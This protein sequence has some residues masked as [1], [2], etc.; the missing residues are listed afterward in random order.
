MADI[1]FITPNKT[2]SIMD[3]SIGTLLLTTILRSEGLD[4]QLLPLQRFGDESDFAAFLDRAVEGI[5][6]LSPRIVSFYTRCDCFHIMLTLAQRLKERA[7]LYIVFGG[8]HAD[9]CAEDTLR[10]IPWVDFV[11]RGEGEHTVYPLFSSLLRR[12]PDLSV[13]GLVYRRN[14]E[15]LSNPRP[16]LIADLD[17]LPLVDYSTVPMETVKDTAK[18]F[19]IDVGRGCPFGCTFCST[20]SFWGRKYRLKSPQR[21]LLEVEKLHREYGITYFGF[22]H[23][24]FTMNRAKVLETCKLLQTLD[25]PIT[26]RCSARIDCIDKEMI[27]AMVLSGMREIFIGIETGSARMQKL[28]NKNLK[29]DRVT[30][31]LQYLHEK[32]VSII[33]S[34]IYGFPEETEA[35]VTDTLALIAQ[36]AKIGNVR[37]DTHMCTFLPGTELSVR[38]QEEL[39]AA[40]FFSDITGEDGVAE[41]WEL[42]MAHPTLFRHFREYKTPLRTKLQYLQVFVRVWTAIQPVYQ[43][44]S[45]SYPREKL[46]DMY[47]DFVR[48]NEA[49]L[50]QTAHR[51]L[52]ERVRRIL[53]N[54]GLA[55]RFAADERYDIICDYYR[56]TRLKRSEQLKQKGS[57]TDVFCFSPKEQ[58]RHSRLQDYSRSLSVVTWKMEDNGTI[59]TMIRSI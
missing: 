17:T 25:F 5:L 1:L 45:E 18:A 41:S 21:I 37:I 2:G 57:L 9:V 6:A 13:E 28:V 7:E 54:D 35:D 32:G 4:A 36:I 30:E 33:T 15:V 55:K 51:T 50:S 24:M 44:F 48:E 10:E 12:E 19:P 29:L 59:R 43:Y 52:G 31:L 38:Y 58:Q 22:A 11:C 26:W 34:F 20:K 47:F 14:G 46:L 16:A 8:P 39:T 23:D 42:I 49:I 53:E 3:E 27:D 56:M 40:E